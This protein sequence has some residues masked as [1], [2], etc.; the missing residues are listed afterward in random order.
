MLGEVIPEFHAHL[1]VRFQ[2]E[3]CECNHVLQR[4]LHQVDDVLV[5]LGRLLYPFEVHSEEPREEQRQQLA[6][7]EYV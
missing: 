2:V 4:I 7:G 1:V 3:F 6:I 5:G